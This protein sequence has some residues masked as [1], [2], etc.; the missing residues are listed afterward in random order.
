MLCRRFVLDRQLPLYQFIAAAR[1]ALVKVFLHIPVI[2]RVLLVLSL[3]L[4]LLGYQLYA[5][6]LLPQAVTGGITSSKLW[7]HDSLVSGLL[8]AAC[9]RSRVAPA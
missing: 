2:L 7:I 5:P 8:V 9:S 3:F 6:T 1:Y 4:V